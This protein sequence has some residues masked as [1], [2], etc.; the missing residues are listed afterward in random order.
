ME[1]S[2]RSGGSTPTAAYADDGA[3]TEMR[4]GVYVF[5]DAQQVELATCGWGNVAL[6]AA[7][8]VVSR[9]KTSVVLDAGSKVLGADPPMWSTGSG[10]LPDHPSARVTALSEHHATI[11]FPDDEPLPDLGTV[12]RVAPNHV[13]AAVDLADEL[14]ITASTATTVRCS[15]SR[16]AGRRLPGPDPG[17]S[18]GYLHLRTTHAANLYGETG[19]GSPARH[20]LYRAGL[21]WQFVEPGPE[22]VR[23]DHPHRP[24]RTTKQPE[25]HGS[26]A[27]C[28]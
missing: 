12:L 23:W 26:V 17:V 15:T 22:C 24:A 5:N 11:V 10:R 4:P 16:G 6:T 1:V 8:T 18:T 3:L 20:R 13:C 21:Q 14:I 27:W 7:A 19:C 2:V 25:P 9:S 28:E